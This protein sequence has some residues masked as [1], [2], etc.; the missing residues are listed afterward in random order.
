M[1]P[2]RHQ[3]PANDAFLSLARCRHQLDAKVLTLTPHQ[4]GLTDKG[5]IDGLPRHQYAALWHQGRRREER[6][7]VGEDGQAEERKQ[8]G[9]GS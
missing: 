5:V 6:P 8:E 3:R 9:Q 4:Q 2:P 1:R 7:A